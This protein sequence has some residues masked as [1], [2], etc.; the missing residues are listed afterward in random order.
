MIDRVSPCW[1]R[2]VSLTNPNHNNGLTTNMNSSPGSSSVL[3]MESLDSLEGF[4]SESGFIASRPCMA[5]I[6]SG[7]NGGVQ[8]N[9]LVSG[10]H[11]TPLSLTH[12][13]SMHP[14]MSPSHHETTPGTPPNL[15]SGLSYGSNGGVN[16]VSGGMSDMVVVD[17]RGVLGN[18]GGNVNVPEYPWMKEKKTTRK[19]SH[20]G[21]RYQCSVT[22]RS[23]VSLPR[24]NSQ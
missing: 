2:N 16:S 7:G 15:N 13:S 1:T 23:K 22:G 6:L 9:S 8:G 3:T 19:N 5:E 18:S 10:G 4:D 11:L 17:N 14:H 12:A 20:Q 24:D 21:N